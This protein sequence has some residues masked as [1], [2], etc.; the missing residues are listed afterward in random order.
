MRER[1]DLRLG[2]RPNTSKRRDAG[3]QLT[4]TLLVPCPLT[5]CP[6]SGDRPTTGRTRDGRRLGNN[7]QLHIYSIPKRRQLQEDKLY[8]S[9]SR[10]ITACRM[11]PDLAAQRLALMLAAY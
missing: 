1:R 2:D 5:W 6:P 10:R 9:M 7:S 8:H 11:L 4:G 3:K